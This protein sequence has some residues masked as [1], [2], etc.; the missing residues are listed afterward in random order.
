MSDYSDAQLQSRSLVSISRALLRTMRPK[1]WV[2]NGMVFVGLVFDAQLLI[3][4][5]VWRVALAF[6]LFCLVAGTVYIINDLAD[7]EKDRQ[8]PRKRL[9]PL[10]SGALP[11]P[12]A[13]VTAVFLP[14]VTL[15]I[16][17]WFSPPLAATLFVYLVLQ[18]AYSFW[19][20]N[21]VVLDVLLI[22]LGFLL[23]VVAGVVVIE[24]SRFSPWLYVVTGFAALFLAV[25][26]RRQELIMLGDRAIDFRPAYRNYNLPLLDDMLR[27][28]TTSTLLSYALYTFESRP[29]R[30]GMIVTIPFAVYA[31][32]RYLYLLHVQGKGGAP[33]EVLLEDV[34]LMVTIFLWG[35]VIVGVLYLGA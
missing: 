3:L 2:K 24:V 8:H 23:R 6:I 32:M 16:A 29:D 27:M 25:G 35:V 13:R 4:E 28:V 21:I 18:I 5:S 9:R 22:A 19:L 1:Q 17:L 31:I 20:K 15:G 30:Y 34:P 14:L 10:A 12:V 11:I 7:I 33:D 26:K